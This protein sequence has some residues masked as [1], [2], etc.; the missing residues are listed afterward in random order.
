MF[1]VDITDHFVVYDLNKS[2]RDL[3]SLSPTI[4]IELHGKKVESVKP[5]RCWYSDYSLQLSLASVYYTQKG[6]YLCFTL[7]DYGVKDIRGVFCRIQSEGM[8]INNKEY[9]QTIMYDVN[10]CF[11]LYVPMGRINHLNDI[12]LCITGVKY[13]FNDQIIE[14][15]SLPQT[16]TAH[17]QIINQRIRS[18]RD[19]HAV[20]TTKSITDRSIRLQHKR[21]FSEEHID[22]AW[23]LYPELAELFAKIKSL[24]RSLEEK[25]SALPQS[26]S[27][28]DCSAPSENDEVIFVPVECTFNKKFYVRLFF[29][30]EH[31]VEGRIVSPLDLLQYQIPVRAQNEP[32]LLCLYGTHWLDPL[33]ITPGEAIGDDKCKSI[34]DEMATHSPILRIIDEIENQV[35]YRYN[36]RV[37][38]SSNVMRAFSQS[39]GMLRKWIE[40]RYAEVSS[41]SQEARPSFWTSEYKLYQYVKLLCPDAIYQYR[42]EWL[43]AQ[44]LDVFIPQYNCAIEYHGKQHYEAI[45]YFGGEAK[46][47]AQ[48]EMDKEKRDKCLRY[49]I[50]LIVWSYLEKISFSKVM[51]FLNK[52]VF[53]EHKND[54]YVEQC[55]K[56]GLPFLVSDLF[57]PDTHVQIK[58][59]QEENKHAPQTE[60]RKFSIDGAFVRSYLS[61]AGAAKDVLVS[62][63]Q[64]SKVL[65]GR[66]LTAGGFLWKRAIVGS[67]ICSISPMQQHPVENTSKSI[68][69]VDVSGVIVGEYDSINAAERKTGI[70]RKSIREVL[71]GRQKKA[72]G[73]FWLFKND[74]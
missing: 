48:R 24:C 57:L 54:A 74:G 58:K 10:D 62:A 8:Q 39:I 42:D 65:S 1:D 20:I 15:E 66:A 56:D 41:S 49:G 28:M 31:T 68:C 6:N 43:D 45:D 5:H 14:G 37:V 32:L 13:S 7:M 18:A 25:I 60:I 36:E 35:F 38:H 63:Q 71:N 53:P 12:T 72:G 23:M 52:N 50:K 22:T 19:K 16:I 59:R 29:V 27:D 47:I 34:K 44:S 30:E 26:I 61:I 51:L 9:F 40:D 64:I 70:N 46:L 33:M 3:C 73:Y 21:F 2:R 55:L 69:Q 17:Q 67:P 11:S 4:D